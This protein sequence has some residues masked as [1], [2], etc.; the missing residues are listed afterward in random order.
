MADTRFVATDIAMTLTDVDRKR[1]LESLERM[2][3]ACDAP[4]LTP[5]TGGVSS[6]IVKVDGPA[7]TFC[8]KCALPKL[9]VAAH[10][11]APVGR[12][13]AEVAW[14]RAAGAIVPGAVPT[15]LAVDAEGHAFAMDFVDPAT[16]PVRK[17]QLRDGVIDVAVAAE[18][19]RRLAKIH[20]GTA[21]RL[22]L[23]RDFANDSTFFDIRLDPYLG[24]IGRVHPDVRA[25]T[26][27]LIER[28]QRTRVALMHGDVSPK[29]ILVGANGPVF[30]DAE[31]ACYGDPAF[32]VAFCLNHLLLKCV[33]RPPH[34]HRYLACFDALARA[35]FAHV[36]WEPADAVAARAGSLLP[37]LLLARVD[38]KSP[39]EYLH[40]E[41][42]RAVVRRFAKAVLLGPGMRP[43]DI[44]RKWQKEIDN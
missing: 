42:E 41:A 8:V 22:E 12:N 10:W 20:S 9:K 33:W 24:E 32:D 17:N 40:D 28:T 2:H 4:V 36:D 35:Y 13:G 37:A 11:T 34:A 7:R 19:G 39:V 21:H 23:A 18:V 31:C 29:N 6:L 38:G 43:G 44:R 3:L 15:I 16:H 27:A 5:L 26:D 25:Q 30:L 14:L 1:L